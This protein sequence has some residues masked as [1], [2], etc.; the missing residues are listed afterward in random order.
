MGLLIIL[1]QDG[2]FNVSPRVVNMLRLCECGRLPHQVVQS[3][4][5]SGEGAVKHEGE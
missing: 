3:S 1:T 5:G 4:F 2:Y